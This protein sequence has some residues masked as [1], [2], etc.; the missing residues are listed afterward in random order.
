M[1]SPCYAPWLS[2]CISSRTL[3]FLTR[4]Q[5]A[6]AADAAFVKL[7]GLPYSVTEQH[8]PNILSFVQALLLSVQA[9]L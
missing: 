7:R 8:L 3:A 4:A 6:G 5:A 9:L 1:Q 2:T